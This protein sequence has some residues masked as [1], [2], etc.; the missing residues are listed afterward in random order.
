MKHMSHEEFLAHLTRGKELSYT[1]R[2]SQFL[3][4][5]R[6]TAKEQNKLV[7]V[8]VPEKG[9]FFLQWEDGHG[10]KSADYIVEPNGT[11]RDTRM[12]A[13]G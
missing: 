8:F 4:Y 2:V 6:K 13:F 12:E 1:E 3:A 7:Y 9:Y 5:A 10:K 11:T